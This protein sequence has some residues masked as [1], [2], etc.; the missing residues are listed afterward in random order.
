MFFM[1]VYMAT[2]I[3]R[4]GAPELG[5]GSF[6]PGVGLRTACLSVGPARVPVDGIAEWVGPGGGPR[7]GG[8][9]HELT[10]LAGAARDVYAG[11]GPAERH[12]GSEFV[13]TTGGQT[14]TA[15]AGG[16]ASGVPSGSRIT[17]QCL[18]SVVPDYEWDA[19]GL[20]DLRS[21]WHVLRLKIEH[22]QTDDAPGHSGPALPGPSCK[23]LRSFEIDHMSRWDDDRDPTIT[24]WYILDLLPT[25]AS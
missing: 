21:D 12:A 23:V 7:P 18:L 5:R 4:D 10:G 16:P 14:F 17:A 9:V 20:P 22:T 25:Q 19:F 13:I 3:V 24:A 8:H 6:L 2:W 11:D 1:W 15:R